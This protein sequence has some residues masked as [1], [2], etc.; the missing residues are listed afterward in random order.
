MCIVFSPDVTGDV[1]KVELNRL[2]AISGDDAAESA[3]SSV[4]RRNRPR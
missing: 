2:S 3:G 1:L 4:H